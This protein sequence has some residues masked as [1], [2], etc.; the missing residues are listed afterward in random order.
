MQQKCNFKRH[1]GMLRLPEIEYLRPRSVRE[2][3]EMLAE[4]G[5]QAM[6]VA[7]GTDLLPKMKRRQME[8]RYLVGLRHLPELEGLSGSGSEGLVIKAGH[9]LTRVAQHPA[10]REHYPALGSAAGS[11]STPQLRNMGTLGGNLCVDTRCNYY[12]A[13]YEWRRAIGFCLKKDGHICLVAPGSPRCWAVC[14]TDTAPVLISLGAYVTLEGAEGERTLPVKALYR[15]DGIEYLTRRGDEVLT[16]VIVPPAPGLRCTYWKLRR[17]GSFDFPILG[18]AA[19][20]RM[21]DGHVR[22]ASIVLGGVSSAPV[23]VPDEALGMLRG[24]KLSAELIAAV[25]EVAYKP[26]RPLDNADLAYLWRKR[27]ARVYIRRALRE[28]AG[29]PIGEEAGAA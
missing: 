22:E 21:E 29:L 5:P 24:E 15:D 23:E 6:L 28:L 9:T 18:V 25:A 26:A 10:V 3:A 2:A 11:V 12:D 8:P 1:G 13:T 20:L 7:G 14:S 17:R 4:K 27:M 16:Q 19:A